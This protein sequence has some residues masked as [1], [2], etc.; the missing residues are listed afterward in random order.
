MTVVCPACEARFRDPPEDVLKTRTLQCSKCEH[1][2]KIEDDKPARIKMDAPSLAPEMANLTD[3]KEPIETNLPVRS[4]RSSTPST[5]INKQGVFDT[6]PA[7][8]GVPIASPRRSPT[9][10]RRA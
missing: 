7:P 4:P 6:L 10:G 5:R 8:T 2:W 9:H 3:G 1:E